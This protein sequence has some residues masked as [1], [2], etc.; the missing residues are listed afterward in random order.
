MNDALT[1]EC[2]VIGSGPGGA[3]TALVLAQAGCD[4]LVVEE[5]PSGS[6]APYSLAEMN[7]LYRYGGIAV[8][9]GRPPIS[10]MEGCCLGGASEINGGLYHRPSSALLDDWARRYQL[11]EF[12]ASALEPFFAANEQQLNLLAPSCT[13]G[14]ASTIIER[15]AANLQWASIRLARLWDANGQRRSMNRTFIPQAQKAGARF[16][17]GIRVEKIQ[18]RT[19]Q[20]G[21]AQCLS[22]ENK[23]ALTIR[24]QHVFV[25]AGAVQTPFLLRQSGLKHNIGDR[26]KLHLSSRLVAQFNDTASDPREGVPSAQVAEFKPHL[27]LGGSFTSPAY[28]AL[29]LA[30]RPDFGHLMQTPLQLGI[31]HAYYSIHAHAQVRCSPLHRQALVHLNITNNDLGLI[32]EATYKLGQM[33]FAAGAQTIYSPLSDGKDF[34]RIEDMESIR[35]G[36]LKG[37]LSSIHLFASCPMGEDTRCCALDSFGRVHGEDHIYVNDASMLPEAPGTNPQALIMALARRNAT[38]WLARRS[39]RT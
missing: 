14:P 24:F 31:F 22:L 3:T 6:F 7:H 39:N 23:K 34:Q 37:D 13:E 10:Y 9:C 26:L 29:W 36:S 30:G 20:G 17:T 25:C 21:E 28:L 5:G 35:Q 2:L 15:G 27:T 33:L 1:C 12:G 11:Q 4:V 16:M 19:G 38:Y 18:P 32:G 8:T